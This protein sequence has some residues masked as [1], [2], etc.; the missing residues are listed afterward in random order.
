MAIFVI[1]LVP[2]A[3]SVGASVVVWWGITMVGFFVPL[4]LTVIDLSS[5]EPGE[6]G[7]YLW[8]RRAFGD[9]HAFLAA[10]AYWT[11][12]V[13][14]LPSVLMFASAQ[15]A[16]ILPVTRHLA[17]DPR[18]L[19]VTSLLLL[20]LITAVNI[21]G[22]KHA[23][24]ITALSITAALLTVGGLTVLAG[25][26]MADGG[27][28]TTFS[29]V[30][31]RPSMGGL[32]GL[33]FLSTLAY[34]FAGVE[35]GSLLG[36]EIRDARRTIPRAILAAGVVV[37]ALYLLTSMTMLI[38]LPGSALTG[39]GGFVDVVG[40]GALKIASP[41]VAAIATSTVSLLLAIMAVGT[42]SVWLAAAARL[43]FVV[44][45]DRFLPA[46]FGAIH[47]R[48]QTPHVA[49]LAMAI[50]AAVLVVL[51]VIGGPVDQVYRLLVALEIVIFLLPFLYL[52]GA[53]V[54]L[55][56]EPV[57]A[58]QRRVPGGQ[59]GALV[60]GGLGW[61]IT[62]GSVVLAMIPGEGVEDRLSFHLT[63]FGSLTLNLAMGLLLYHRGARRRVAASV[64][65][66][67]AS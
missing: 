31:M 45:L 34:M 10:W 51:S 8:I 64:A 46:R 52:F 33:V 65:S 23:A 54:R 36:D 37:T 48:W 24:R 66:G 41:R 27:S 57:E 16:A 61:T 55:R 17:E 29:V 28:A 60:V 32:E 6:G 14:Y 58:G 25:L 2:V 53:V 18:F 63:I 49:I 62:A 12:T 44:G 43:P 9:R 47:P 59:V 38:I 19:G 4:A 1:R 56:G 67:R 22:L 21:R 20:M 40:A 26:V 39:L 30:T 3:A 13:V 11:S 7:L 42:L 15:V 50:P 5:R 35:C